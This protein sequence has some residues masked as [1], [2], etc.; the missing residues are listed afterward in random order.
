MKTDIDT[1]MKYVM[2]IPECGCWVWIGDATP[3]GYGRFM[4]QNGKVVRAHR[5]F[6]ELLRGP[7]PDGLSIDHLCRVT[8]C[9]NP[10]HLEAVTNKENVL[11]GIGPTARNAK[12]THCPLGHEYDAANTRHDKKSRFCREC[13]RIKDRSPQE[14]ARRILWRSARRAKAALAEGEKR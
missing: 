12:K 1:L 14:L 5:V 13:K 2:P 4:N 6:Y 9:V 7:I 8:S 11:R 3:R 10:D